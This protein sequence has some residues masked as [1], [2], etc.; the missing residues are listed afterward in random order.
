ME[1]QRRLGIRGAT[2]I[3]VASMLG[4]GVFVVWAPATAAAGSAVLVAL[5]LAAAIAALNAT[6]TTRLAMRHPV[7]VIAIA[8]LLL[9]TTWYPI[10]HIGTEFMPSLDEGDLLYTPTADPSI[11]VTKSKEILQQTDRLIASFPEVQTVHGK[12]GRAES[13]T[14]GV[15]LPRDRHP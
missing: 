12:I 10:S 11:S 6:S 14:D 4:A 13:A 5:P 15:K 1:L 2:A 9:A 8:L 3:G 7:S